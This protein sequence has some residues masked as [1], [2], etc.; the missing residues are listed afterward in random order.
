MCLIKRFYK[1]PLIWTEIIIIT[2]AGILHIIFGFKRKGPDFNTYELFNSSPF[3][4]FS[5]DNNCS[6]KSYNI[7]H[8]WGGLRKKE[9]SISKE[10]YVWVIHDKANITKFSY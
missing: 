6:N 3:F 1:A 7:F 8:I 9:Y 4:D 2:I 5:L 10:K